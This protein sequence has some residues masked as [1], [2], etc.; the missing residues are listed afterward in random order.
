M[1]DVMIYYVVAAAAALFGMLAGRAFA[2]EGGKHIR[3]V[4]AAGYVGAGAGLMSGI[5]IGPV[6]SLAAQYTEAGSST[7]FNALEVAGTSLFWGTLAGAAGG[8][9]IGI[10]IMAL[11]TAWLK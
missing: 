1:T 2:I 5:F 4:L 9:V 6:L 7:W 10:V 3:A 11:P 8:I